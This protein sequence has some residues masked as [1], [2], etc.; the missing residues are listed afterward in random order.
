MHTCFRIPNVSI[1]V[2]T[3]LKRTTT[4]TR[5]KRGSGVSPR[6]L[7]PFSPPELYPL[8]RP[9]PADPRAALDPVDELQ[10]LPDG[11]PAAPYLAGQGVNRL[12][13]RLESLHDGT[14]DLLRTLPQLLPSPLSVR[15]PPQLTL[16]YHYIIPLISIILIIVKNH[17][18]YSKGYCVGIL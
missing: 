6:Q 14:N 9:H 2:S 17:L 11:G 10:V 13:L 15:E 7:P 12:R 1:R 5:R 16:Q 8:P 18:S 3:D 4:L